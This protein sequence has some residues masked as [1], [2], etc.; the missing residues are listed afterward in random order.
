MSEKIIQ[1]LAEIESQYLRTISRQT[2]PNYAEWSEL[3]GEYSAMMQRFLAA[4]TGCMLEAGGALA[5]SLEVDANF[6]IEHLIMPPYELGR[7]PHTLFLVAPCR[8]LSTALMYALSH[9]VT[10]THYQELK[11]LVR[12]GNF[13]ANK[14]FWRVPQLEN[15]QTLLEKTTLG[16]RNVS[17]IFNPVAIFK[18]ACYP[19]AN[20]HLILV[21]R[22]PY[23]TYASWKKNLPFSN[24]ETFIA[25]YR[26]MEHLYQWS[27]AENIPCTFLVDEM[28]AVQHVKAS[29]LALCRKHGLR[30]SD[31][32]INWDKNPSSYPFQMANPQPKSY[33][34]AADKS[35]L[36]E[37]FRIVANSGG[38]AYQRQV[39]TEYDLSR[40]EIDCLAEA[41]LDKLYQNFKRY[42]RC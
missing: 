35:D 14:I 13:G 11:E 21:V 42:A 19:M 37:D 24:L 20:S 2:P 31:K 23:E 8:S 41:G 39:L 15:G 32:L 36:Q 30:F 4:E 9:V 12:W 6:I 18:Q 27:R 40:E 1:R 38:L 29:M 3:E 28:L 7:S 25:A 17:E 34:L 33:D 16:P 5:S 10:Y 26:F 22:E